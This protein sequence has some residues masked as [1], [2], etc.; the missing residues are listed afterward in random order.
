VHVKEASGQPFDF[1]FFERDSFIYD[2]EPASRAVVVA[3]RRSMSDG[4]AM[5]RRVQKAFYAGNR[6]VTALEEL[7][8]IATELGFE[9]LSF[10]ES[11]ASKEAKEETW[12]DYAISQR[13]GIRGFPAL[14]IGRGDGSPYSL[15]TQ[16][17][18]PADGIIAAIERWL[19]TA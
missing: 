15:V 7:A 11:F 2:T 14:I 16:G 3:R 10:C 19:V 18:Q 9:P 6:D 12:T 13:A 5:L 17:F 1:A 8:G 4:L